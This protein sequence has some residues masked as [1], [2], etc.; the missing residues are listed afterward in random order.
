MVLCG[1]TNGIIGEIF[2]YTQYKFN[3]GDINMKEMV[4]KERSNPEILDEGYYKQYHYAIVSLGSHPCAYV[5]I[6]KNNQYYEKD[7]AV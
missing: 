1:N 4:Y 2:K 6:S 5:E 3:L 7:M